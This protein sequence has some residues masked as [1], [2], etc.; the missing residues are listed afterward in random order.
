[1]KVLYVIVY[2]VALSHSFA[3][4]HISAEMY[5]HHF[6]GLLSH[7]FFVKTFA[8]FVFIKQKIKENFTQLRH[9]FYSNSTV[10]SIKFNKKCRQKLSIKKF[11]KK[12]QAKKCRKL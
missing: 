3:L 1:M 8:Q 5:F 11:N 10:P 12:M 2:V 6:N 4:M 7:L 9:F